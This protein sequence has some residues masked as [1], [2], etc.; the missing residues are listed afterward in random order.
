MATLPV[1]AVKTNLDSGADNPAAARTDL[2]AHVDRFNEMRAWATGLFGT[3][4]AIATARSTLSVRSKDE[5]RAQDGQYGVTTGSSA[6]FAVTLSPAPT[7]YVA[8]MRIVVKLNAALGTNSTINVNSLGAKKI[9]RAQTTSRVQ[10]GDTAINQILELTYNPDLDSAAGGFEITSPTLDAGVSGWLSTQTFSTSG[11]WT[12]P[13]GVTKIRVRLVGAG[14]G[15][16]SAAGT[17]GWSSGGSSGGYSE[18]WIDVSAIASVSVT[19]GS[20]GA[21]GST[22]GTTSFGTHCSATGGAANAGAPG[23]GTGGD[24]NVAGE[25]GSS[26]YGPGATI[27]PLLANQFRVGGASM[28]APASYPTNQAPGYGGGGYGGADPA[29]VAHAGTAGY[30]IVEEFA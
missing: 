1:A 11:T 18:K 20:A 25:Y 29:P 16:L 4:G 5:A 23:V 17:G 9:Y 21:V 10:T 2:A 13:A 26:G 6:T 30:V 24:L 14:G 7:A 22:G 15:G 19:V 3:D 28:L 12:R 8:G 27:D